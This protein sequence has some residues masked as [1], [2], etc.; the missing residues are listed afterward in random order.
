MSAECGVLQVLIY[1]NFMEQR[2]GGLCTTDWAN[3]ESHPISSFIS[4][5]YY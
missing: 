3:M 5:S 1:Y 4:I 2:V